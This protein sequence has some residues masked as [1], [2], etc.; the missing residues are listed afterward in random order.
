MKKMKQCMSE[1]MEGLCGGTPFR[2]GV[3][4]G[5][6]K[7]W[8]NEQYE[9]SNKM[10]NSNPADLHVYR[11]RQHHSNTT[12]AGVEQPMVDLH[13][14]KHEMPPASLILPKNRGRLLTS[15]NGNRRLALLPLT[16]V[17]GHE[18]ASMITGLQPHSMWLKPFP[19]MKSTNR[20]LK[21]TA[22][23]IHN[24]IKYFEPDKKY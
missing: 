18:T 1:G 3:R 23:E 2:V 10:M 12:P 21:P 6:R 7:K 17:N 24:R 15:V 19:Y 16:S 5:I 9:I 20:W 4:E 13:F 8:K 22:I 14:Y 11:N